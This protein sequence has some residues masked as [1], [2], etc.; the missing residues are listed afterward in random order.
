MDFFFEMWV[1]E[2]MVNSL[3]WWRKRIPSY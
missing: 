2:V 1:V 3:P